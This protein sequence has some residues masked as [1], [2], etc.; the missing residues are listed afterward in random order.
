ME[1]RR[2]AKRMPISLTLGVSDLY[3]QDNVKI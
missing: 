1:E 3:K 2:R